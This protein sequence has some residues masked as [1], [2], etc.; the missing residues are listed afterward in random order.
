M[1]DTYH[2]SVARSKLTHNIAATFDE[3]HDELVGALGDCIPTPGQGMSCELQRVRRCFMYNTDWVKVSISPTMQ[4]II[5][6][7]TSRVLVGA[8]L[9][10]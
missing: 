8:P 10:A 2:R 6:R 3:V 7:T 1:N 5:C 4:R 9:C